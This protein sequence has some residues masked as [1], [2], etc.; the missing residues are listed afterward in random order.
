MT[1]VTVCVAI[2]NTSHLAARSLETY[3]SQTYKDFDIVIVDDCSEDSVLDAVAPFC[4]DLK[5]QVHRFEHDRGMRGNSIS[6]NTAFSLAQGPIILENTPEVMLYNTCIEEMVDQIESMQRPAWVSIRTYN[7]TPEDQLVIDNYDWRSDITN[8]H[9]MP[10]FNSEWTR[11]NLKKREFGTHQTCMFYRDDWFRY[12]KRQPLY[13]DYGSDDP[14]RAGIRA[15]IGVNEYTM[16]PL[17][18][19]QWHA[20][21]GFWMS[22]GKAPNWNL[23]GHTM[24]N[25]YHD[26]EVPAG[27]TAMI[28]DLNQSQGPYHQMTYD[29]AKNWFHL[30]DTV[31]KTGFKR[32]DGKEW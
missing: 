14:A 5:I 12:W 21:I 13:A 24:A 26:P 23:W 22:Q 8:L 3:V 27:G 10:N 30:K 28:W 29:E 15:R 9:K 32:K 18:Y 6:F 31:I 7:I 17:V 11:N 16:E 19:H 4:K 1:H 2:W 25:H 20:P